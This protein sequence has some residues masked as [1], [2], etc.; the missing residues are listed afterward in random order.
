LTAGAAGAYNPR[1][2]IM[3][4]AVLAVLIFVS[5]QV[6]TRSSA[7]TALRVLT[8]NI[9]HGEGTDGRF[10]LSRTAAIITAADADL[11]ALQE[12]DRRTDRSGGIDQLAELEQ[13]TGMW[14]TFGKAMPFQRGEYG[15]ATLSRQP[16]LR[17]VNR[18]LPDIAG[19]EPR[20]GLTIDVRI[21]PDAPALQF[22][23]THLDQGREHDNRIV[24]ANFLNTVLLAD[25]TGA[26]ILAGD[27]NS[28]P[29]TEVMQY[30][31]EHWQN[32]FMP[33]VP[34][35][36]AV[37]PRGLVDHVLV[38]PAPQFRTVAARVIEDRIA[39]DHRPLLISLE[40]TPRVAQSTR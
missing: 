13:L 19:R 39:S 23:S 11:V 9:H 10:D 4:R 40:W 18:A 8:Y 6:S 36:P 28:R 12:V 27:M 5:L 22:T 25:T 34:L 17:A 30:L 16:I 35:P 14:G 3:Y 29:D 26:A 15:V 33:I 2:R 7:T 21:D 31:F 38:R 24:Q 32:Q 37:P 20:T 1:H